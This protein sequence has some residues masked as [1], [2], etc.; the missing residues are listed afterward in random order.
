MRHLIQKLIKIG[1]TLLHSSIIKLKRKLTINK[2]LL[3]YFPHRNT[4]WFLGFRCI[5]RI[6]IL[7]NF[8]MKNTDKYLPLPVV[9]SAL[10]K[11]SPSTLP[12]SFLKILQCPVSTS[13]TSF[14]RTRCFHASFSITASNHIIS[15]IT[16]NFHLIFSVCLVCLV[17]KKSL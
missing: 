2:H 14:G 9:P 6:G 13:S 11:C 17:S 12:I 10:Y 8:L 4:L 15:S 1:I 3:N 5:N 16:N 7:S